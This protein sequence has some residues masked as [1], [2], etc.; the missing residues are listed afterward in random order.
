M[1]LTKECDYG[2]RVIR[3]LSNGRKKNVKEI[4]DAEHVPGQ[5]AYKILKKLERAGLVRSLRGRDGGYRLVKPL[6]TFF[7]HDIVTAID[8]NL[9]VFECLLDDRLCPL[10]PNRGDPCT[11]HIEYDRIQTA[12]VAEMQRTPMSKLF[13]HLLV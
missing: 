9:F 6:D 4:C 8:E 1:F 13:E 3:A 7:I 12:L 10:N 11:I 5:Y 2:I